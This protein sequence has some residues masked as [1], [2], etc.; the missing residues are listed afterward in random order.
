MDAASLRTPEHVQAALDALGLGIRIQF[1][2]SSTATSPQ[3]AEAAGCE[4]GAIAKSLCFVVDGHPV[5]VVASGDQRVDTRKLA[6]L[7]GVGRKKVKMADAETTIALTG[8]APGGVPPL[9]HSQPLPVLIDRLL[10]RYET[11]WAA[12]GAPNA[13]FP[14]AY[15]KLVEITGGQVVDIAEE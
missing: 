12:A 8:Y 6:A 5:I 4:L 3:A 13:I 15:Q 9:G 2:E 7:Y 11:V 10:G 1:F 14:I